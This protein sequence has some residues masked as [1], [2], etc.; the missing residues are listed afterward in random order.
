[1]K[2][3]KTIRDRDVGSAIPDPEV[4]K[5]RRERSCPPVLCRVD[6]FS[7]LPAKTPKVMS[8]GQVSGTFGPTF[9]KTEAYER[10]I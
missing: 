3:I 10:M 8:Q 1:M 2:F 7:V 6:Y 9:L 4:H 5:E